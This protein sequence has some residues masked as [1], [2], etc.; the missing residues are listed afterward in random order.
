MFVERFRNF[1]IMGLG[2]R[3]KKIVFPMFDNNINKILK[4]GFPM[5]Y[6]TLSV[7][8]VFLKI[9]CNILCNAEIFHSVG[10]NSTQL[11]AY[12]EKMINTGFACKDDCREIKDINFLLTKIF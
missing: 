1:C 8:N 9:E 3:N 6:F 4:F 12:P 11:T 2:K 10:H 5:K 7:N